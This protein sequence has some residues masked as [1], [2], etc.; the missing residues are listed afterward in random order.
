MAARD[1]VVEYVQTLI[2][3]DTTNTGDLATTRGEEPAALWVRDRLEEVGYECELVESGAPGRLNVFTRLKGDG[4]CADGLVIHGHLDVVP[5]VAEDW[6]VDPF[7]AEIKDGCIWGRGAV[8]MKDMVG[9]MVAVARELKLTGFTPHRDI[10]FAFFADEESGSEYG[11]LWIAQNR[12]DIFTGMKEAIGEVGGY[13]VTL[14]DSQGKKKPFYLIS[15]GEKGIAWLKVT[16]HG[17]PGHA[18]LVHKDNPIQTLAAALRRLE[19]HDFPVVI[20]K[21]LHNFVTAVST[22]T[23]FTID[24]NAPNVAEELSQLGHIASTINSTLHDTANVTRLESGYKENVVPQTA[25]AV[26]DCRLIPGRKEEFMKEM[27]QIMGPKISI[28]WLVEAPAIEVEYNTELVDFMKKSVLTY[29]PEAGFLPYIMG[30]STDAKSLDIMGIASYGFSPLKLPE[31]FNFMQLFHGID[32]R[33]PVSSLEFGADVL[34]DFV[35]RL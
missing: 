12:P 4:T 10:L 15:T 14:P 30:A 1:N 3:F 25:S 26:L 28:E 13:S 9:M 6:S 11:S 31:D 32:E 18:S 8:D 22:E 16:A 29:D 2:R 20:T 23:N 34:E 19:E 33:V 7:S 21:S 5:A 27:E 24:V 17:T 35:R